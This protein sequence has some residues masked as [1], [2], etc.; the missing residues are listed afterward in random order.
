MAAQG[1]KVSVPEIKNKSVKDSGNKKR[2]K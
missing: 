2:N 1:A